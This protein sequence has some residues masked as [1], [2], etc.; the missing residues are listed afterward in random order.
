MCM[1]KQDAINLFGGKAINL[2]NAVGKGKSA[3]SQWPE[4]LDE[5]KKNIVI[6]VAVRKGISVPQELLR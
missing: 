2:A 5:D 1:K 3:I 6:G 4:I